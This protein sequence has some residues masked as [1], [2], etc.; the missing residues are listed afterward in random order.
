LQTRKWQTKEGQDRYSTEIIADQMQMLG[1]ASHSENASEKKESQ[2][3]QQT[4]PAGT[5]DDFEDAPF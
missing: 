4:V 2:P 5:F 3:K 1:S